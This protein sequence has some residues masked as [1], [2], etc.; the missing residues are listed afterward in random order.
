MKHKWLLGGTLVAGVLLS[1]VAWTLPAS[2]RTHP[3]TP[4]NGVVVFEGSDGLYVVEAN[5]GEP[6]RIP[7]T[8]PRDGDPVWSP[9]GKRIAFDRGGDD[10]DIYVINADGSHRQQLTS[11][12][13]DDAYPHWEPHG[14]ALAFISLRE[15][16]ANVYAI[17]LAHGQSRRVAYDGESSDWSLHRRI[18]FADSIG[19]LR[20]VLPY[21]AQNR[22]E[23]RA[24]FEMQFLGI[25]ISEDDS[26]IVFTSSDVGPP[27]AL[28]AARPSG[29]KAKRVLRTALE[30]YSPAWSPDGRWITFSAGAAIDHL[31]VYAVGADG[32]MLT[33]LAAG[34]PGAFACCS[35]WSEKA[36]MP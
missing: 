17:D 28:Y 26:K 36:K 22:F 24:S 1:L 32:S 27:H 31:S 29:G 5:G 35:D 4:R 2:S 25:R 16:R 8:L 13:E 30:I 21:G 12:P 10:R 23:H 20:S 18:L 33:R 11:A 7:N 19:N 6:R 14:R 3:A 9:D 15:G 34:G